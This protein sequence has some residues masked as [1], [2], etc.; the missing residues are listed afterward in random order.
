M[1]RVTCLTSSLNSFLRIYV[2]TSPASP[3]TFLGSRNFSL[4]LF[5]FHFRENPTNPIVLFLFFRCQKS[6]KCVS[7]CLVD[8]EENLYSKS[9]SF[10]PHE[11]GMWN[12]GIRLFLLCFL[13]FQFQFMGI[14]V[15]RLQL[16]RTLMLTLKFLG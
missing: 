13:I 4:C 16:M 15:F 9:I 5:P 6:V 1:N 2:I 8:A 12:E 10:N 3:S 11:A 7:L 14:S